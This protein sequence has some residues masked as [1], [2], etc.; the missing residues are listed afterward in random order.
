MA[1]KS[2][3]AMLRSRPFGL[4][5]VI[6]EVTLQYRCGVYPIAKLPLETV[7]K[8]AGRVRSRAFRWR[9]APKRCS[10]APFRRLVGPRNGADLEFPDSLWKGYS[11][12]FGCKFLHKPP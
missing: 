5:M 12:K 6:V 1:S 10:F 8:V 2:R 3:S 9:Q 11:P 4:D 7:W